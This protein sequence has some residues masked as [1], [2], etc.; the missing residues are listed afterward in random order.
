MAL[1]VLQNEGIP[2]GGS[3]WVDPLG[4]L[5]LLKDRLD[6]EDGVLVGSCLLVQGDV[7][8]FP[9]A[10]EVPRIRRAGTFRP[11]RV[12]PEGRIPQAL[13]DLQGGLQGD[14]DSQDE[15]HAA[16]MGLEVLRTEINEITVKLHQK[17]YVILYLPPLFNIP[18]QVDVVDLGLDIQGTLDHSL[19]NLEAL[20]VQVVCSCLVGQVL[21]DYNLSIC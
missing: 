13:G 11:A 3:C 8:S 5:V 12:D 14:L 6:M 17:L 2:L 9:E 20:A 19:D 18:V 1:A 16:G 21:K 10:E 7:E 4:S 15:I